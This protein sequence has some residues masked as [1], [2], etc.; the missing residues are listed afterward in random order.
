[1]KVME[2]DPL[3]GSRGKKTCNTQSYGK[4]S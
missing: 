1:M 3:W 2:I 4:R